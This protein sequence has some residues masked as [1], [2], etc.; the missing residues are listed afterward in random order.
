MPASTPGNHEDQVQFIP[1]TDQIV[2]AQ[3]PASGMHTGENS[4]PAS[5]E[6]GCLGP[7]ARGLRDHRPHPGGQVQL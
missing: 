5:E 1:V 3:L 6:R 7:A 4:L 2:R